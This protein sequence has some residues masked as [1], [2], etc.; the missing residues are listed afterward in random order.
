[1]NVPAYIRTTVV[2]EACD[3]DAREMLK[4]LRG[5]GVPLLTGS[6]RPFRVPWSHLRELLPEAAERVYELYSQREKGELSSPDPSRA[7]LARPGPP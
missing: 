5:A 1:M 4:I 2:A 6:G 3:L 7:R